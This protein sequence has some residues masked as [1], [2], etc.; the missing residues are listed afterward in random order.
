MTRGFIRDALRYSGINP[1][2]K[3]SPDIQDQLAI[4]YA[5]GIKERGQKLEEVWVGLSKNEKVLKEA[6]KSLEELKKPE[7]TESSTIDP[8]S[9][10]A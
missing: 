7:K 4:A 10:L 5:L 9:G 6:L 8:S 2:A 3:F 1:N